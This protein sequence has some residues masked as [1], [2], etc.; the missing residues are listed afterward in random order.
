MYSLNSLST[1]HSTGHLWGLWIYWISALCACALWSGCSRSPLAGSA[2]YDCG[3]GDRVIVLERLFCVYTSTRQ[4]RL[5]PSA[6]EE[7]RAGETMIAGVE[8]MA[9]AEVM[10]VAGDSSSDPFCPAELPEVYIYDTLYVCA[11]EGQLE[12]EVIEAVVAAWS[13][14]HFSD[15]MSP[16]STLDLGVTD[17]GIGIL[18]VR[19]ASVNP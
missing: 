17:E 2:N 14:A 19:D 18:S 13:E 10:P 3:E 4:A 9:G 16:M 11:A 5:E 12:L 8:S 6:G 15:D 1:H 7:M